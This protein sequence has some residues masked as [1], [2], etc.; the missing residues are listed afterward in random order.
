MSYNII[1]EGKIYKRELFGR[2]TLAEILLVEECAA[3]FA[4]K[5]IAISESGN[6]LTLLSPLSEEATIKLQAPDEETLS[7][8]KIDNSITHQ[9]N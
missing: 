4:G 2:R 3:M 1:R 8:F 7:I 9:A 5:L 6:I